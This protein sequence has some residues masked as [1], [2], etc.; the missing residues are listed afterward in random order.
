MLCSNVRRS[1]RLKIVCAELAAV[2]DVKKVREKRESSG[3]LYFSI[4]QP[5]NTLQQ[6]PHD[7]HAQPRLEQHSLA[8][9]IMGAYTCSGGKPLKRMGCTLFVVTC[10]L[11]ASTFQNVE[12]IAYLLALDG[13]QLLCSTYLFM[14]IKIC[15]IK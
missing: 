7:R 2:R 14:L 5:Y 4:M 10:V 1:T 11:R 15:E 8:V 3:L 12:V 6:E 9:S 13:L